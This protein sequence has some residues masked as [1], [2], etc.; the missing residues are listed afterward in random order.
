MVV[1]VFF[2]VQYTPAGTS[3]R[4]SFLSSIWQWVFGVASNVNGSRP[5]IIEALPT[6][7]IY[8][9]SPVTDGNV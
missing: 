7:V 2:D 9:L 8:S 1:K 4:E 3:A 5:S 6:V